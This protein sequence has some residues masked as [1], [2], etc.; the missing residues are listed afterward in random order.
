MEPWG[1]GM[2]MEN[3]TNTSQRETDDLEGG[4]NVSPKPCMMER[5]H[6]WPTLHDGLKCLNR[7]SGA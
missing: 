5:S 3:Q 6:G 1:G 4:N 2:T 7:E